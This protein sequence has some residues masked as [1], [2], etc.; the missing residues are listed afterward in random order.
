MLSA[1]LRPDLPKLAAPLLALVS[2]DSYLSGRSEP[3][4][5]AFYAALLAGAPRASLH[6]VR[7]ARHFMAQDRPDVVCAAIEAFVAGLEH[8]RA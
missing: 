8:A 1:D 5:R 2:V 4:I 7:G 6:L 3:D